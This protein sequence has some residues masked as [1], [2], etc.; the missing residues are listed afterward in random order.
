M[1]SPL[2]ILN[3]A[4]L[5]EQYKHGTHRPIISHPNRGIAKKVEPLHTTKTFK[6]KARATLEQST[7]YHLNE[8]LVIVVASQLVVDPEKIKVVQPKVKLG[9]LQPILPLD[10]RSRQANTL[11]HPTK[12]KS[13]WSLKILLDFEMTDLG[14]IR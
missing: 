9:R 10:E 2:P 4:P 6:R 3:K 7:T 11:Q 8:I 12:I 14:I 5:H 13:Q 1:G